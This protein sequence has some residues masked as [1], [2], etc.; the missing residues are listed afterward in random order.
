MN[1]AW[2][3]KE[4]ATAGSKSKGTMEAHFATHKSEELCWAPQQLDWDDDLLPEIIPGDAGSD[5]E[6]DSSSEGE[7]SV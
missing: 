3:G 7:G 6:G 2:E 1:L 4:V 5:E